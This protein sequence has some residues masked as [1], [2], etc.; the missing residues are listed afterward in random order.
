V[1]ED[2]ERPV[3]V[4][5]ERGLRALKDDTQLSDDT[6]LTLEVMARCQKRGLTDIELD[7]IMDELIELHG[8]AA[9]AIE[10]IKLG[11]TEIREP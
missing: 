5:S 1:T 3:G 7:T 10:A 4:I 6:R 9:A 8:N 11:Y 2:L